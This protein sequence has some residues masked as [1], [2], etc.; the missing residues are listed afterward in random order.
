MMMKINHDHD[1]R[2]IRFFGFQKLTIAHKPGSEK[3]AAHF[4]S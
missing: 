2:A 1:F 4:A 3:V